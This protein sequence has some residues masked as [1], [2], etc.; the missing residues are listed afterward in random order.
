[1]RRSGACPLRTASAA[2]APHCTL[3]PGSAVSMHVP[4]GPRTY[5]PVHPSSELMRKVPRQ[6]LA[7]LRLLSLSPL[8][9]NPSS[10]PVQRAEASYV[11]L[12]VFT[13]CVRWCEKTDGRAIGTESLTKR[14]SPA[15]RSNDK[16]SRHPSYEH[17][18]MVR[19]RNCS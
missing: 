10:I 16:Y 1:M 11:S 12:V 8:G 4:P 15:H 14:T 3:P 6:P 9:S 2:A 7:T 19:L 13:G 5:Q 17:P 18:E